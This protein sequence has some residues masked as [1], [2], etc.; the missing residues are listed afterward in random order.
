MTLV[1]FARFYRGFTQGNTSPFKRMLK[2]HMLN[3]IIADIT[4]IVFEQ[5]HL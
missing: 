5:T 3:K 1:S 2:N 4:D